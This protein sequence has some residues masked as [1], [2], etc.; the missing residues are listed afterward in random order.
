MYGQGAFF[1]QHVGL[2]PDFGLNHVFAMVAVIVDDVLVTGEEDNE[3]DGAK[4]DDTIEHCYQAKILARSASC[5]N[6]NPSEDFESLYKVVIESLGLSCHDIFRNSY[7]L[8]TTQSAKNLH[9][10]YFKVPTKPVYAHLESLGEN[11]VRQQMEQYNLEIESLSVR[12][13]HTPLV[14]LPQNR[15]IRL[16]L[17]ENEDNDTSFNFSKVNNISVLMGLDTDSIQIRS[18]LSE[19]AYSASFSMKKSTA[20][21]A[22]ANEILPWVL[23]DL[24]CTFH[25]FT[26]HEIFE[27]VPEYETKFTHLRD[28][29]NRMRACKEILNRQNVVCQVRK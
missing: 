28:T 6:A 9:D 11:G 10:H 20:T 5:S 25:G 29:Y 12:H 22:D 1:Q 4:E 7:A 2:I 19:E 14:D 17:H 13:N 15:T 18:L 24:F 26:T 8:P 3:K 16:M 27:H 23:M 21:S